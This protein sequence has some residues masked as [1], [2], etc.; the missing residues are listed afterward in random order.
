[1]QEIEKHI[2]EKIERQ[3]RTEFE[4]YSPSEMESMLYEFLEPKCP[5]QIGIW[6]NAGISPCSINKVAFRHMI[7]KGLYGSRDGL[8]RV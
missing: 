7:C 4:G 1:M 8:F 5:V 2:Q 6:F 3:G